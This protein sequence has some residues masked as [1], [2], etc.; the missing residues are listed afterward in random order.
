MIAPLP[1]EM[2]PPEGLRCPVMV[3]AYG[4]RPVRLTAV[5]VRGAAVDTIGADESRPMP[6]RVDRVFRFDG[7]LYRDLWLAFDAGDR[8]RLEELWDRARF[9][10][11]SP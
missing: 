10:E 3:R 8:V 4:D 6:F 7:D 5:G 11:V 1:D 2:P 9:F